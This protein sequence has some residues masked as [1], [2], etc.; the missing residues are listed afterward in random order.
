MATYLVQGLK[1]PITQIQENKIQDLLRVYVQ[2]GEIAEAVKEAT[3]YLEGRKRVTLEGL[4]GSRWV[5]MSVI[6][7]VVGAAGEVEGRGL[8]EAMAGYLRGVEREGQLL[9]GR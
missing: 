2:Y 9:K 3:E 6:G 5:P 1:I 4:V 8:R 7:Q